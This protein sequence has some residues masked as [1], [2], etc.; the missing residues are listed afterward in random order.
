MSLMNCYFVSSSLN[1]CSHTVSG[2]NA[3]WVVLT[4]ELNLGLNI[5]QRAIGV[6]H[7]FWNPTF[8]NT[9]TATQNTQHFFY[10]VCLMSFPDL[11]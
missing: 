5:L 2:V 1:F 8:T 7:L 10:G 6:T 11:K 3:L 4:A 9:V